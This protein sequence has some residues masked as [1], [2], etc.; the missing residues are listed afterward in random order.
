MS[1]PQGRTSGVLLPLFSFRS[2]TDAGIGDFGGFGGI[3]EWMK[4]AKQQL[5]MIL[6]LLPTAPGD[7]SPYSTRS[8]F[9]FNPLYIDLNQLPGATDFTP[10]ERASLKLARAAP[11][12]QYERVFPLKEA[13]LARAFARFE[14]QRDF[15]AFDAFVAEQKDWLDTFALFAALSDANQHRPWWEWPAPLANRD[16]KALAE[17]NAQ[18]A[19]RIRYHAWLQ[20]VADAQW[21]KVRAQA[22]QAGV[23]LCGDEPFIIGKDSADAWAYPHLLRTEGRLGVPPDDFSADG[24]DWGL[25]WFDF[26]AMERDG[27][28]WLRTRARSAAAAFDVRRVDHA[29]GYF[30]QYVRDAQTPRG[31]FIPS[32]EHQQQALGEKHFRL[33][34]EGGAGIMAEDLGVM[35]PFVRRTLDMLQLPGYRVMRWAREDGVYANPR[36]YPAVSLVTTGT[37]D[38]ETLREWWQ[39]AQQWEREAVC[40]TFPELHRFFPPGA[41]WSDDLHQAMLA[42]AENA[43]SNLCIIPWQDL[44]G[45][46]TRVNLPGTI[47]PHNWTYRM[48]VPVEQLTTDG[49]TRAGAELLARLTVGGG[50]AG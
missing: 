30:R 22:K 45:E 29:I 13:A 36:Q 26:E 31:R 38:T 25:P 8:A 6:P 50:R 3:F 43:S 1:L 48:R 47:G 28:R 40:R 15:A 23:L 35:T 49:T 21:K 14:A 37:H 39:T 24:Q 17:A 18:H 2:G 16:A 5:L 41:G 27:Y 10:E 4:Q 44:Y 12:V 9:G 42:A 33:L 32:Q 19:T 34:S 11:T 7:P 46:E 20:W